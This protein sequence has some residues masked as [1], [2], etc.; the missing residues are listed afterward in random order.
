MLNYFNETKNVPCGQC[1]SCLNPI[2]T[3][4]KTID[5]QKIL[6]CVYRL[7]QNYGIQHVIDV[8]R[9]ANKQ[10][11]LAKQH[12]KLSTYGL[13]KDQKDE[14]IKHTI[15]QLIQSGFYKASIK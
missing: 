9:G 5:A 3:I 13:C 12:D 1:D 11:V 6:S 10:K 2:E 15:Q 7:N 4:D 8:L 14:E